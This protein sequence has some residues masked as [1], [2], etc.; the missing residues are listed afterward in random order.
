M[1]VVSVKAYA[2]QEIY[3]NEFKILNVT[4]MDYARI[5]YGHAKDNLQVVRM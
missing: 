3:L 4:W 5:H 2:R 1:I